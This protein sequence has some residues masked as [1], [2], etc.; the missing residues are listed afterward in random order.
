MG[1]PIYQ[2]N[3]KLMLLAAYSFFSF[4]ILPRTTASPMNRAAYS[5]FTLFDKLAGKLILILK[6]SLN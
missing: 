2:N 5:F 6:I 1:V 3:Q 4:S